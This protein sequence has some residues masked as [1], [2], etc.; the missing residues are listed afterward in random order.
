MST[1]IDF[2]RLTHDEP[3]EF[4]F[5]VAEGLVEMI[6]VYHKEDREPQ[7]RDRRTQQGRQ[8]AQR[9]IQVEVQ[10]QDDARKQ[11]LQEKLANRMIDKIL[12][13]HE[14]RTFLF[15]LF[16]DLNGEDESG[17]PIES[18]DDLS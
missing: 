13:E 2:G 6:D 15:E 14:P 16:C 8:Q 3:I 1:E 5:A 11:A 4:C 7:D 17:P 12:A 10:R 18:K 9:A